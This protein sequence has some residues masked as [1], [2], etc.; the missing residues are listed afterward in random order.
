MLTIPI[1][2]LAYI[3]TKARECDAHLRLA[4]GGS[5][6]ATV[7]AHADGVA[8]LLEGSDEPELVLREYP[9]VNGEIFGTD[10]VRDLACRADRPDPPG[11]RFGSRGRVAAAHDRA[12]RPV[13][14]VPSARQR[15][16]WS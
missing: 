14:A 15:P 4:Q 2:K 6:V 16:R 7:A 5:I 9:G 8:A 12:D 13:A 10:S 11:D 3:I 1:E